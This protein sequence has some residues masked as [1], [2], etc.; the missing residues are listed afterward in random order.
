VP[1][2]QGPGKPARIAQE[3]V[4]TGAVREE[5]AGDGETKPAGQ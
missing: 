3:E 4:M 2:V 1:R 5:A